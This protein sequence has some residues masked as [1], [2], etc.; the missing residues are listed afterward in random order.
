MFQALRG[1]K[2]QG[3]GIVLI[4]HK[5]DEIMNVTDRVTVLRNGKHVATED[6]ANVTANKLAMMMIGRELAFHVEKTA[7]TKGKTVLQV[8]RLRALDDRGVESVKNVS[9]HID[10]GEIFGIAGVSGNGQRELTEAI[11]GLRQSLS[12]KVT[13]LGTDVT[14]R[15]THFITKLGVAYVPEER[16]RDGCI[17]DFSV[18]ENLILK[19]Q[20][21]PG[22]L[23][24]KGF[25]PLLTPA[26]V[27]E[28]A[29]K[30]IEQFDV[31]TTSMRS[32]ARSLSGGNLQKMILARELSGKPQLVVAGQ[33][34]RGL[35]IA[36]TEYVRRT[37]VDMRNAGAAVLLVSE[38]LNEVLSLSDR[39]A[40]MSKGE[41]AGVFGPGEVSVDDVG[42]MMTGLKR[43][44]N[45]LT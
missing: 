28:K 29:K 35:D 22:L 37:I 45:M 40:V 34:T 38:D 20:H 19:S 3:L 14:N 17:A 21:D 1:L 26:A 7:F 16:N 43:M 42:L 11:I 30:L 39:V 36:A 5:L 4:T 23:T 18:A 2:A 31:R 27:D 10:Q 41:F 8:D 32:I 25:I 12:G 9:F 33:P 44:E 6:S 13:L 24:V 15:P